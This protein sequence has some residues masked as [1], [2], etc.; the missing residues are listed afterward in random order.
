MELTLPSLIF[1][2]FNKID[3]SEYNYF[4]VLMLNYPRGKRNKIVDCE[5][6]L[7]RYGPLER[8]SNYQYYLIF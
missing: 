3:I 8:G 6:Y 4:Q 2:I 7:P 5:I 1:F